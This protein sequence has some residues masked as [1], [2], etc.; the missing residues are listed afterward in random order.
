MLI[1]A[2]DSLTLLTCDPL[3]PPFNYRLLVNAARLTED[4][5]QSQTEIIS[6]VTKATFEFHYAYLLMLGFLSAFV[7]PYLYIKAN[8]IYLK[9]K[10]NASNKKD[11][12]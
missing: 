12:I 8:K 2:K 11:R 6:T 7:S 3:V 9:E 1:D 4:K 5:S 10:I